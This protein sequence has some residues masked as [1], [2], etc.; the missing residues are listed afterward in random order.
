M[1]DETLTASFDRAARAYLAHARVQ[2]S[3]AEWLAEWIPIDRKGRALEVGAGPGVFTRYL[4]PWAGSFTAS[5]VSESMCAAGRTAWPEVTWRAMAAESLAE[6]PWDWIFS[7]SMLQWV[8]DPAMVFAAWRARLRPGG[9][10]LVGL[11]TEGSLPE[12]R[13]IAGDSG[14]LIWRHPED[15]RR[16]LQTAGFRIV[17]DESVSREFGYASAREFLRS[18]HG[19]GAAPTRRY[20]PGRL[21]R[22]MSEYQLSCGRQAAV[23]ATW[24]YYRVEAESCLNIHS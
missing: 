4:L 10:L 16:A 22:L 24:A 6:G 19:V 17:R 23:T 18:L 5:D 9:K 12:W 8:A 7:S 20:L 15:W 2:E 14:P 21:R 11:F 1:S 3:M 13:A